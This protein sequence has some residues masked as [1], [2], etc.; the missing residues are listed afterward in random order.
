MR[1]VNELP[2]QIYVDVPDVGSLHY[3]MTS[4][5]LSPRR[6]A[7]RSA[8]PSHHHN[9]VISTAAEKPAFLP[10]T[11]TNNRIRTR[12]LLSMQQPYASSSG[13]AHAEGSSRAPEYE[14]DSLKDYD[15]PG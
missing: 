1:A 13:Y 9:F 12:K 14:G 15:L 10:F 5:R 4:L 11:A 7:T 3:P 6:E 8:S 2:K